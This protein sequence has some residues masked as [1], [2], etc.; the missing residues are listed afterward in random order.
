MLCFALAGALLGFLRWNFHP[1]TI[2]IGTSG[3]QFVGYTLAVLSILGIGQGRGRAARPRRPDHR[4]V[5][6]H[7]PAAGAAAVRRSRRTAATSTTGCSTWACRTADTVLLIYGICAVLGVVALL[8]RGTQLYAFLGVFIVSGLI[9]F[10]P[11]RGAFDGPEELRGRVL[12]TG[13]R[14]WTSH[15]RRTGVERAYSHADRRGRAVAAAWPVLASRADGGHRP[16]GRAR[17]SRPSRCS[18]PSSPRSAQATAPRGRAGGPTEHDRRPARTG[19]RRRSARQGPHGGGPDASGLR[20]DAPATAHR[21]RAGTRTPRDHRRASRGTGR[22]GHP[23]TDATGASLSWPA[24]RTSAP[25]RCQRGHPSAPGPSLSVELLAGSARTRRDRGRPHRHLGRVR[26]AMSC[27]RPARRGTSI[28]PPAVGRRRG[29]A[30]LT[31]RWSLAACS[32]Y[33]SAP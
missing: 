22:A 1:A 18:S 19:H 25:E 4:H 28:S 17:S 5:L 9:L 8:V 15:A 20:H 6:D 24:C 21:R 3:V 16:A 29:V 14:A 7:R 10:A 33:T 30:A 11:T 32:C 31:S 27:R 23:A 12:R 2:F 13:A 26:P